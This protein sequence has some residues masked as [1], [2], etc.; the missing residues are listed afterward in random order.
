MLI[1]LGPDSNAFGLSGL[2][3]GQQCEFVMFSA[4][5]DIRQQAGSNREPFD[6][7]VK[8]LLETITNWALK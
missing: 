2:G 8:F 7:D 5:R 4:A 6:S 3:R 1:F